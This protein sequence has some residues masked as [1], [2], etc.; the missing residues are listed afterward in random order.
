VGARS[1]RDLCLLWRAPALS[2]LA[3]FIW[4]P[5]QRGG[6]ARRR[7]ERRVPASKSPDSA[8]PYVLSGERLRF[9]PRAEPAGDRVSERMV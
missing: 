8:S 3:A 6:R 4:I 1:K 9:R 7:R 2:R 5:C